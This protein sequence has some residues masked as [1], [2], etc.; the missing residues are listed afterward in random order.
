MLHKFCILVLL[1]LVACRTP[2]KKVQLSFYYWQQTLQLNT[3]EQDYLSILNS[4]RLYVKFFDIDWN[5]KPV[6]LAILNNKYP[7]INNYDI[8]PTVFITNRT[9]INI[10]KKG[11]TTLVEKTHKKIFELLASM[12][13]SKIKE[14][15][16]DCDWTK[17]T[18]TKYFSFLELFKNKITSQNI[19]LSATIR[20]HQIKYA[21][22]TGIPPI[23][24]GML[25]FY[26]VGKLED[27]DTQNSI[28]DPTIAQQYLVNFEDYPLDLDVALPIFKWGVLYRNSQL[29]KLINNLN[30]DELADTSRFMNIAPKRYKVIKSTY[31]QGYYLYKDDV[32]RLEDV[33]LS[34][35]NKIVPLLASKLQTSSFYLSFYHLDSLIIKDYPHESIYTLRDYFK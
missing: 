32:I 21:S 33:P 18:Q 23:D 24:R 27:I 2:Q 15:Q 8:V 1:F 13:I 35:L 30:A 17:A 9:F 4:N 11:I 16:F 22:K 6:P 25:M 31:L 12:N 20:L 7:N 29:I 26:N 19:Q 14:M 28:L 3:F 5:G 34:V 10:D